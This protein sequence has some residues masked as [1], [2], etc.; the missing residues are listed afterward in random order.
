MKKHNFFIILSSVIIFY[1]IY[2]TNNI[3][4]SGSMVEGEKAVDF[5]LKTINEEVINL[6]DYNGKVVIVNF[7]TTWCAYCQEEMG[8]LISF[9][10]KT[11][12]MDIK[13][14]GVNITSA[15]NSVNAVSQFVKSLDLPFQ[16]VLDVNGEVSKKYHVLGIPTT[17]IID[18]KGIIRKKILGPVTSEI[19]RNETTKF[20]H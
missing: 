20:S 7:W 10:A 9:S 11:K 4:A 5:S 16:V 17:Y 19:L 18:Q 12:S 3:E 8:E 6:S 1:M 14:L 2:C 13:V 15:E